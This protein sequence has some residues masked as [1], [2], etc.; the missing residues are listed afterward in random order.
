MYRVLYCT[1][2][3]YPVSYDVDSSIMVGIYKYDFA[4]LSG[5]GKGSGL[6][7]TRMVENLQSISCSVEV[8][9]G[10]VTSVIIG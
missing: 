6:V 2:Y 9:L 5:N 8:K 1:V 7:V 3:V 10:C 4:R